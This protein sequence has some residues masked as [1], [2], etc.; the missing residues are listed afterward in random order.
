MLAQQNVGL[1]TG[2]RPGIRSG[3]QSVCDDDDGRFDVLTIEF[4][5]DP[6][7]ERGF[8]HPTPQDQMESTCRRRFED[9]DI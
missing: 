4:L 2:T 7:G 1:A 8:R 3:W 5:K 9:T 6:A